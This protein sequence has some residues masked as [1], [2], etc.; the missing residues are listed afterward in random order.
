MT[1]D[2]IIRKLIKAGFR[3]THQ[4]GSHQK[5]KHPDGRVTVVPVPRK[6]VPIGTIQAIEDQSGVKL[7]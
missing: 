7:L 4:K 1:S 6:D 2:E 5:F 3:K